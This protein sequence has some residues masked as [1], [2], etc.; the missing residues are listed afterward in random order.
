MATAT[1]R[2]TTSIQGS[3]AEDMTL[4]ESRWF[5]LKIRQKENENSL[6]DAYLNITR[7]DP[8]HYTTGSPLRFFSW[9]EFAG[10]F[11]FSASVLGK[12]D[13]G[14]LS[15]ATFKATGLSHSD[16]V[17][18]TYQGDAN[19]DDSYGDDSYEDRS[20]PSRSYIGR[21]HDEI[22]AVKE[23]GRNGSSGIGSQRPKI[24][25]KIREL[26]TIEG[27]LIDTGLLPADL[28]VY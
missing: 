28:P 27:Y 13:N 6:Q 20:D 7:W 1:T 24:T 22:A 25:G 5:E 2:I 15:R 8:L 23:S 26:V 17:D 21:F 18:E 3:N 12:V 19:D 11:N 10:E 14:L 16:A 9:F 4:W